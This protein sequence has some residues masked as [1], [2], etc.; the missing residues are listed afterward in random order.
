MTGEQGFKSL[1]F[2]NKKK[3]EFIFPYVDLEGVDHQ[4]QIEEMEENKYEEYEYNNINVNNIYNEEID[5]DEEIYQEELYGILEY[6]ENSKL[7]S[8]ER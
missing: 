8:R 4:K 5:Y 3:K 6:T 2:Y 1:N 7:P